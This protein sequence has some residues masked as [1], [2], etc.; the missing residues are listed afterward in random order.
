MKRAG[1]Q[2]SVAMKVSGHLTRSV[3]DRYNIVDEADL[4]SAAEKVMQ[5]H[6]EVSEHIER[7]KSLATVK[8]T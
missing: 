7:R 8:V 2:D 6:K 3:F 5:F 4:K 1:V